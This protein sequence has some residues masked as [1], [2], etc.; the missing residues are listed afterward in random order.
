MF[1]MRRGTPW[2]ARINTACFL[3]FMAISFSSCAFLPAAQEEESVR[4]KSPSELYDKAL[5]LYQSGKYAKAR[6]LF[7]EYVG[8]YPDSKILRI[9]IYYLGHCYQ[10]LGEDQEA[11]ALY[12]RIIATYGDEDFWG[13]Q[14][15]ARIQQIK[16][17]S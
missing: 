14:A 3:I 15:M 5:G 11:L 13:A 16:G 6:N 7:H 8:Q 9:A 4:Y 12:N 10:M 2:R 1:L 17:G